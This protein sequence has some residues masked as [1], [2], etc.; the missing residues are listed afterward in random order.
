MSKRT[1]MFSALLC[2]WYFQ[3]SVAFG[4]LIAE[5]ADLKYI[6]AKASKIVHG[7][8]IDIQQHTNDGKEIYTLYSVKVDK[9]IKGDGVEDIFIKEPG[10]EFEENGH[11]V[12]S[13]A[14]DTPHFRMGESGYLYLE[15]SNEDF[16]STTCGVGFVQSVNLK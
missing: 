2:L 12:F 5:C 8:I 6:E 7:K 9:Y 1:H 16:Y 11:K 3:S 4:A 13:V 14:E 10:G 15:Q